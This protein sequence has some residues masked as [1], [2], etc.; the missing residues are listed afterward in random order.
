VQAEASM[1]WAPAD[2]NACEVCWYHVHSPILD[3]ETSIAI[4]PRV[5]LLE[6]WENN[7][8]SVI[9]YPHSKVAVVNGILYI[10]SSCRMPAALMTLAQ[11]EQSFRETTDV[12]IGWDRYRQF[13]MS[14]ERFNDR[15]FHMPG[16]LSKVDAFFEAN[17]I[18]IQRRIRR[19]QQR[20]RKELF[21]VFANLSHIRIW[22]QRVCGIEDIMRKI[23]QHTHLESANHLHL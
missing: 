14:I 3:P 12:Y 16:R 15:M 10:F 11:W 1:T 2:H 22:Q 23:L 20:K 7:P 19:R 21:E 13:T 18:T 4:I 6:S 17:V 9:L 8:A 5:H